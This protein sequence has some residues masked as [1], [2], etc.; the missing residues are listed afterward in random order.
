MGASTI[1]STQRF[2]IG[3]NS[4]TRTE[5]APRPLWPFAQQ[6]VVA[7]DHA[8]VAV[9]LHRARAERDV[10]GARRRPG[11]PP[12]CVSPARR[13]LQRAPPVCRSRPSSRCAVPARRTHAPAPSRG[14]GRQVDLDRLQGSTSGLGRACLRRKRIVLDALDTSPSC[15]AVRNS[16]RATFGKMRFPTP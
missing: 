6:S 11:R 5:T 12:A 16:K 13:L 3:A 8:P 10:D 7:L 1:F 4:R 2:E 14:Y 15:S 9:G